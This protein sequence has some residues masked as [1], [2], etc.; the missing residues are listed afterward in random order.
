M[1]EVSPAK[2]TVLVV[3]DEIFNLEILSEHLADEGYDVVSAEDGAKAWALLEQDPERFDTVLLDRMMPNM[4]GME[5]LA[6]IKGHSQ[7][8][9][10]PVVMQTAKAARQDV[11]EGLQAGAYYY[12]T[13]PFDKETMLAIVKTAVDDYRSYRTIQDEAAKTVR[14]LSLLNQGQFAFRTLDEARDLATLLANASPQAGKAVIGLSELLIN[15][16]EHGNLGITYDEKS[17]LN[18]RGEWEA[19][20]LQRLALPENCN[21]QVVVSFEVDDDEIRFLISDE[22]P[23]FDW[24][25]YLEISPERAFDNHGRGIAMARMLSFDRVEYLGNGN[26]VLAVIS[27]DKED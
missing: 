8:N 15:A 1:D 9:M 4:D 19:E 17:E 2:P 24:D 7:L 25:S 27:F 16:V 26:Q 13:K 21:K 5:V 20:V 22:G 3:D 12:L 14:T 10:L 23:G 6:R 11:L 18:E